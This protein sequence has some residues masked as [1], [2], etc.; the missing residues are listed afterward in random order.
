LPTR[1]S[2]FIACSIDGYIARKDGTID[3]LTAPGAAENEDYG[4]HEFM[5]SVD[6]VVIGRGSYQFV[7]SLGSWPYGERRVFVLSSKYPR[8]GQPLPHSATGISSSPPE[9]SD[10]MKELGLVRAYID[11]GRTIQSF[12]ECGLIDDLTITRVPILL[13]SGIPLFG[14]MKDE[15]PLRHVETRSFPNGLVQSR[16][17]RTSRT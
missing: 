14:E 11:G 13:G 17:E 6:A 9:L 7:Q 15:L 2:V 4:Y 10:L 12:L 8:Q 1:C 16:Y 5:R 3:W